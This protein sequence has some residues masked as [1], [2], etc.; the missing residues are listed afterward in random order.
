MDQHP[1]GLAPGFLLLRRQILGFSVELEAGLCLNS[2]PSRRL[3]GNK[4][5]GAGNETG[6]CVVLED[7]AVISKETLRI[8][9]CEE[10]TS[11]PQLPGGARTWNVQCNRH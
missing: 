3:G 4:V 10:G 11:T 9:P 2:F 5:Y 8:S 6:S 7:R 1:D